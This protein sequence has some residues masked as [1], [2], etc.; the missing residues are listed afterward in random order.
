MPKE[1]KPPEDTMIR[2]SAMM[3]RIKQI[4]GIL[5]PSEISFGRVKVFYT[6]SVVK[7]ENSLADLRGVFNEVSE[8][9]DGQNLSRVKMRA[10]IN[11][12]A[13][14]GCSTSDFWQEHVEALIPLDPGK[15]G[16]N[17]VLVYLGANSDTRQPDPEDL[18]IVSQNLERS[19][20]FGYRNPEEI[21][22][23]AQEQ[24]YELKVFDPSMDNAD[25]GQ[26]AKLCERFGG[27]YAKTENILTDP[28]N[29][30]CV[31]SKDSVVVAMAMVDTTDVRL[32]DTD[33][34]KMAEI[35]VTATLSGYE[36]KGIYNGTAALLFRELAKRTRE[37]QTRGQG[38][39]LLFGECNGLSL[40]ILIAART[41]GM[42]FAADIGENWGFPN[43]GILKQEVPI[44]WGSRRTKYNDLLPDYLTGSSLI[45]LH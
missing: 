2:D 7:D 5:P 31:A 13:L 16:N 34:F 33:I 42:N 27:S 6:K 40:G 1:L 45:K 10:I 8:V 35:R 32:G 12:E 28:S 26:M 39:D 23:K 18:R 44:E 4:D 29:V 36:Q 21:L 25:I 38:L 19:R 17:P 14:R 24:G 15:F 37:D 9:L 22:N 20:M 41:K 3:Q 11:G 30:V 43:S